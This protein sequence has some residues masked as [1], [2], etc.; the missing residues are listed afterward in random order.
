MITL[1]NGYRLP[2]T[3]DFGNEWF[4]SLEFNIE[5][6][7]DHNHDGLSSEKLTSSNFVATVVT[8][9][10]G[11]LV[12][13]LNGYFRAEVNT[14]NGNDIANYTVVVRDPVTK[15]QIFL[16]VVKSGITSVYIYTNFVQNLEVV[17]GV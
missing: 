16:K 17:F 1:S 12:N 14:P 4:P 11:S 13:Q 3:G 10:A 7:N 15:E 6:L 2:E 5:R 8:V 9:S